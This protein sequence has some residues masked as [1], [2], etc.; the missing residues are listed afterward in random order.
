MVNLVGN[1]LKFTEEGEVEV[2]VSVEEELVDAVRL[3]IWVR[4]T[5]IGIPREKQ[6]QIFDSFSQVDSSTSRRFGGTGLGLA[7]SQQLVQMMSGR[8][9]VESEEGVG[10]TFH[11]TA[12]FDLGTPAPKRSEPVPL[13]GMK[14]LVVDDH[15]IN[16]R[17]LAEMLKSWDMHVALVEDGFEAVAALE[18]EEESFGLV[19]MDVMMPGMDGLETVAKIRASAAI[20]PVPVLLL[21]SAGRAETFLRPANWGS[22]AA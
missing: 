21:S 12:R 7:I 15:A 4:D 20:G 6:A 22:P 5:G 18:A 2:D 16:R 17:I 1:A 14:V 10:S 19:L 9:W 8:I 3:H 11:F 13:Q